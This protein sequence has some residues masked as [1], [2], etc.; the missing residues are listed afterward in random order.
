MNIIEQTLVVAA[1]RIGSSILGPGQH[2]LPAEIRER[3]FWA[4]QRFKEAHAPEYAGV[5]AYKD[6]TT[7]S[8]IPP[9]E[10]CPR[11]GGIDCTPECIAAEEIEIGTYTGPQPNKCA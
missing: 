2:V 5:R 7:S 6:H 9:I 3:I 10:H 4:C 11:C 1:R 8:P